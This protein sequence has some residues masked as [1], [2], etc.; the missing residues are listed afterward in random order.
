MTNDLHE[1][2]IK[3]FDKWSGV[4]SKDVEENDDFV[5]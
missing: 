5:R 3:N 1:I 2:K 4:K